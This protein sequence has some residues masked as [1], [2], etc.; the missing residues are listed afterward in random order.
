MDD[1]VHAAAFYSFDVDIVFDHAL[2]NDKVE[3]I[4]NVMK[5]PGVALTSHPLLRRRT[6][7]SINDVLFW[8]FHQ[9]VAFCTIEI[10]PIVRIWLLHRL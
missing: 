10:V 7:N 8:I 5:I 4:Q 1:D 9:M 6:S 2:K 3:N